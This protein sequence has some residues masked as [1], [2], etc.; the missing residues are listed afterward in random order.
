MHGVAA[1]GSSPLLVI[2]SGAPATGKTTIVQRI[3]PALG[4]F[5]LAKDDIKE[6]LGESLRPRSLSESQAL[7]A[8]TF[9]LL[10]HLARQLTESGVSLV[11]EGPFYRGYAEANLAPAVERARAVL[12]HCFAQREVCVAR[13]RERYAG[14][15]RHPVHF[16]GEQPLSVGGLTNEAW[17]RLAKPLDLRIPTLVLD[18]SPGYVTDLSAVL[19]FVRS[20]YAAST[21][22]S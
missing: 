16:D 1:P 14:G 7:G 2:V 5:V 22:A 15:Q 10:F 11:L 4:L 20:A 18:T 8:T 17:E 9:N 12:I 3:A 13:F 6:T 21:G 19:A